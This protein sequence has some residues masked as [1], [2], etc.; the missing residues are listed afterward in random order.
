[1]LE[2]YR[3]VRLAA[4]SELPVLIVGET[5]T[6]KELVARALHELGPSSQGPFVDVN[7]AA[8]PETLAESELFGAERGAYTGAVRRITGFLEAANSGTLFLDEACSLLP[9]LQAKLLRAVEQQTFYRVGDRTPRRSRFRLVAALSRPLDELID[10]GAVRSDFA[11]RAAGLVVTLPPLRARGND[12]QLLAEHYLSTLNHNGQPPKRLSQEALAYLA[13]AAWPGNV[14]ELKML[15]ERLSLTEPGPVIGLSVLLAQ[16]TVGWQDK[17]GSPAHL[18]ALLSD[19]GWNVTRAAR[20]L[21][22]HR[23]TVHRWLKQ[24]GIQRR[25]EGEKVSHATRIPS[26]VT[27][28]ERFKDRQAQVS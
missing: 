17:R 26:H 4:P 1:M 11:F 23:A 24:R 6:G 12:V 8:L 22:V 18:R 19:S 7:C 20:V 27:L 2:V 15:M 10:S 5:G 3:Q 28:D 16:Q 9:S 14:R 21:G 25:H 13:N